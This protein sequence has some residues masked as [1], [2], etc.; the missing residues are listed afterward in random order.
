MKWTEFKQRW[1]KHNPGTKVE[2]DVRNYIITV[3]YL[4]D[5]G[6]WGE[7]GQ[8]EITLLT[9]NIKKHKAYMFNAITDHL[10]YDAETSQMVTDMLSTPVEDADDKKWFWSPVYNG[11]IGQPLGYF[12]PAPGLNKVS[13][14]KGVDPQPGDG[15][16][17][18]LNFPYENLTMNLFKQELKLDSNS[19]RKTFQPDEDDIKKGEK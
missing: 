14:H 4:K 15:L 2:F 5:N 9:I 7:Y 10:N 8:E 12:V 11:D 17:T 3:I 13:Y 16:Y 19:F 18:Q 6:A 1:E